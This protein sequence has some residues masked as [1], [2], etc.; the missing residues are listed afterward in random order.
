MIAEAEASAG[1]S[2]FAPAEPEM[3]KEQRE[4]LRSQGRNCVNEPST[5]LSS[6]S[7][8]PPTMLCIFMHILCMYT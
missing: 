5:R 4:C 6:V 3:Y 1:L 2:H 8:K 7:N